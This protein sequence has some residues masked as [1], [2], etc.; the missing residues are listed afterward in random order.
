MAYSVASMSWITRR[1]FDLG[2][3]SGTF[4]HEFDASMT[5]DA[6]ENDYWQNCIYGNDYPH[7]E[8][9]WLKTLR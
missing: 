9:T 2:I 5:I 4:D 3:G 7:V 8:G 1:K 6:M